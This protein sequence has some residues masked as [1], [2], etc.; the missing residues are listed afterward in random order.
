MLTLSAN[1]FSQ[2]PTIALPEKAIM[3]YYNKFYFTKIITLTSY[4]NATP[5]TTNHP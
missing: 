3:E 1:Y 2:S 5:S 4:T